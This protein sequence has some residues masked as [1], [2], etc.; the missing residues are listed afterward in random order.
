MNSKGTNTHLIKVLSSGA[1]AEAEIASNHKKQAQA[2]KLKHQ[3][4]ERSD[5][6]KV[7]STVRNTDQSSQN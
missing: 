1:A 7:T 3:K 4:K 6:G 2:T 5:K